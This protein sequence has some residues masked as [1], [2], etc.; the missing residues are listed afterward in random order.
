MSNKATILNLLS[1]FSRDHKDIKWEL[2][3]AYSDAKGNNINQI[4]IFARPD[5]RIIGIFS[6]RVET[7]L[8][9]FCMYKKLKKT[10]S[11]NIV[12]MLLDMIN[13]SKGQTII[14]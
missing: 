10:R 13:Y 5:N 11:E 6:Y 1:T 14:Q 3:S 8:V 7:G 4:K 12:D 9:L 2:K